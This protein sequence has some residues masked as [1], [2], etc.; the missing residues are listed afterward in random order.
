MIGIKINL[1]INAVYQNVFVSLK[2]SHRGSVFR[3]I[4]NYSHSSIFFDSIRRY[5]R[6]SWN[7]IFVEVDESRRPKSRIRYRWIS[8]WEGRLHTVETRRVWRNCSAFARED[9]NIRRASSKECE[10]WSIQLTEVISSSRPS[11]QYFF[12]YF[13]TDMMIFSLFVVFPYIVSNRR[14]RFFFS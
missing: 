12:S 11:N 9:E 3:L 1:Q 10:C 7:V 14:D 6:L 4:E 5:S 2:S 13:G 8:V